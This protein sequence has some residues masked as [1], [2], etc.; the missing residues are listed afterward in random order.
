L[1]ASKKLGNL[2]LSRSHPLELRI[3]ETLEELALGVAGACFAEAMTKI[4]RVKGIRI[5]SLLQD[6]AVGF[7]KPRPRWRQR[8]RLPSSTFRQKRSHRPSPLAIAGCRRTA[9]W[10]KTACGA[11]LARP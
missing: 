1:N 7:A 8:L 2:T 4:L 9:S 10:Q 5:F 6:C 3:Y 11:P